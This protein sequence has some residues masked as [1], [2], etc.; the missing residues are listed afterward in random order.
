MRKSGGIFELEKR[1]KEISFLE[2]KI[3]DKDFW[4]DPRKSKELIR[5]H[6]KIK[7]PIET[8]ERLKKEFKDNIAL[9]E[10]C[11]DDSGALEEINSELK[12]IKSNLK[13]LEIE[14]KLSEKYDHANA[15]VMLHAGA[16]GTEACDWCQMLL[17]MYMRW[18]E[19][20]NFSAKII[21]ILAGEEVG[22]KNVTFIVRGS[23]AYGLL[24]GE[25]GVHRLVRISPF[26]ANRRRHTSFASCSVSPEVEEEEIK[27]EE[28]DLK[29]ETFRSSG[30]GGQHMQK[31]ESAIRITHLPTG[32]V[33]QS[34]SDRSQYRN[35]M[36]ALSVLKARLYQLQ[37][38]KKRKEMEAKHKLKGDIGW[39]HQIRSYVF[40]P[41]KLVKD[42]RT[43]VQTTDVESVLDG[44]IDFFI[45]SFLE[46]K[47]KS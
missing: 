30:P 3:S 31:T 32:I 28:K 46:Q 37:L 40:M 18:V 35:K 5:K 19:R 45:E 2:E 43:G 10:L 1:K 9:L 14:L 23:Y 4:K 8:W 12:R 42:H 6:T 29:I 22:I 41:Y 7:K 34:Q 39:G 33:V 11:K 44:E 13:S 16:G 25:E 38:D 17:R 15:I 26:D 24:K 36:N 47:F 21:D 20:K 27:L